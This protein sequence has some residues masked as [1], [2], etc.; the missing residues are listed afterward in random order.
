MMG[1]ILK[2]LLTGKDNQTYNLARV[3]WGA[4]LL[5][6]LGLAVYDVVVNHTP[7]NMQNFGIG[8]GA[9]LAAGG[10]AI[11]LQAKTEPGS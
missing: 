1:N 3:G 6:F 4:S 10:G 8:L 5:V 2:D 11:G 9:V 7:F